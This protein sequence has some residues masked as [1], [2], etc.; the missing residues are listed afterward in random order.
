MLCVFVSVRSALGRTSVTRF[1]CS[2]SAGQRLSSKTTLGSVVPA[3]V[4]LRN[5]PLIFLGLA[6]TL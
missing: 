3:N 1:V 2:S 5:V 4:L 6:V